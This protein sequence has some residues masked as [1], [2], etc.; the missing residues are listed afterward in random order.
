MRIYK[1]IILVYINN[2]LIIVSNCKNIDNITVAKLMK[3]VVELWNR[4]LR[5]LR[6][7]R[8]FTITTNANE[9]CQYVS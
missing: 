5:V 1:Y 3:Y 4:R 2:N 8:N 7:S 6:L 9:L